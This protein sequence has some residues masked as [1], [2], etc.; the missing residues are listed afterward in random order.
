MFDSSARLL[1]LRTE[2]QAH[3]LNA[4]IIDSGDAHSN[5]Y[6]A[7]CDDRRAWISGFTGSAGTAVV[8]ADAEGAAE[9]SKAFLWTD[10]RYHQ[11]AA[12]QIN[13]QWTLMKHGVPDVP[14]W[15]EWLTNPSH[16]SAF[17]P[18]GSRIGLDPS[19]ITVADYT[20]LAPALE[21]AKV[22][23]VP[24]REN[25]VDRAWDHVE[26]GTRPAR[27]RNEVSRLAD[28]FAGEKARKKL[29]RVRAELQKKEAFG[30]DKKAEVVGGAEK[31]CWGLVLTQLDEIAWVLNLRGSD[32]PYNPVFFSW[33]VLPTASASKPTLFV[34]LDQ[35]PQPTYD[36][37]NQE[38]DILIEPYEGLIPFLEGVGKL[39]SEQDLVILPSATNLSCALALG[40][41]NCVT[42]TRGPISLLKARKNDTEVQGFRDCHVRDG[43]A[44]VRY[45]SWLER[46]LKQS[47]GKEW[48]EYEAALQLEE[49]RK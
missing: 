18:S 40:L 20:K 27:P 35:I 4:Y 38:L 30:G 41:P 46:E 47:G 48:R 23:L 32:I 24:I 6:T 44:L 34:D 25:L 28:D 3:K 45:F 17:L 8:L 43:V 29:E 33:L 39:L 37:L 36:Y 15:T 16:S 19:L 9:A 21:Q 10:G 7:E 13:D 31:R 14:S 1:A 42:S 12:Q 26:P 11:Q 5:E 2:M 49:F 22:E